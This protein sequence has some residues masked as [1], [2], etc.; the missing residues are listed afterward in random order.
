M[1]IYKR[2]YRIMINNYDGQGWIDYKKDESLA[3]VLEALGV[4]K[5]VRPKTRYRVD[6]RI[7]TD[8]REV[9]LDE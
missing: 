2:E 6:C 5:A 3:V 8:W 4:L 7:K 9:S 1:S